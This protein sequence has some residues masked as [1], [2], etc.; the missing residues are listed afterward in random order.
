MQQIRSQNS[1][2]DD[3]R[4]ALSIDKKS[5]DK[6]STSQKVIFVKKLLERS[7]FINKV[8]N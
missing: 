8:L 5:L 4:L 3:C 1:R 7:L 2:F 6:V